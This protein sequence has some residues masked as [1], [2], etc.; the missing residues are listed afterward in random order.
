ME[1]SKRRYCH[2]EQRVFG[3]FTMF[4]ECHDVL[5]GFMMVYKCFTMLYECSTMF[6]ECHDVLQGFMMVYKCFTM[7][8]E[9][10]TMFYECFTMFIVLWE[11][12]NDCQSQQASA[13]MP[14]KWSHAGM[15]NWNQDHPERYSN[16]CGLYIKFQG[17][18]KVAVDLVRSTEKSGSS[19]PLPLSWKVTESMYKYLQTHWSSQTVYY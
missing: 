16:F 12:C 15:E 13:M 1:F 19:A 11:L 4:Y 9:C 17:V 3:C 2:I 6:Y 10:S 8:Y 7:L 5:Q 14:P 18:R